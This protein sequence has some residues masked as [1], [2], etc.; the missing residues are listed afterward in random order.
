VAIGVTYLERAIA[1]H[2]RGKSPLDQLARAQ[3]HLA[4]FVKKL[5]PERARTMAELARTSY[6]AA[7]PAHANAV[8]EVDTFLA[9]LK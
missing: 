2:E 8:T 3:L 7:G 1:L 6:R 9:K 5:D 4:R